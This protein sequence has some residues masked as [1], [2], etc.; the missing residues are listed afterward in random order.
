MVSR[1]L[2]TEKEREVLRGEA[3]TDA[4]RSTV[5]SRVRNRLDELEIDLEV[6][7][8]HEPELY[9]RLDELVE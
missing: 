8:A 4:Y 2:L 9:E 3:G 7:A 6:L 1:A 5:R